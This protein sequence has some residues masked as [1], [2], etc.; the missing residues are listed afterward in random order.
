MSRN[1]FRYA[2]VVVLLSFAIGLSAADKV[3]IQIKDGKA[4]PTSADVKD[5]KT[6][7]VYFQNNGPATYKIVWTDKANGSP[8]DAPGTP[9]DK[10]SITLKPFLGPSGA[11]KIHTGAKSGQKYPYD[12]M[13]D[14]DGKLTRAGSGTVVVE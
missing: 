13:A 9:A 3:I 14:H 1:M 5:R 6:D 8:F 12:I 10:T 7:T 4:T 11:R 2:A